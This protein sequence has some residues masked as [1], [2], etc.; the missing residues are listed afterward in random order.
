MLDYANRPPSSE[1][2]ASA[3]ETLNGSLARIGPEGVVSEPQESDRSII[4]LIKSGI[5]PHY[6]HKYSTSAHNFITTQ[7]LDHTLFDE[8]IV[9][10]ADSFT[11]GRQCVIFGEHE[12]HADYLLGWYTLHGLQVYPRIAM[13]DSVKLP[14][15]LN[16]FG[17][18]FIRHGAFTINRDSLRDKRVA[19]YQARALEEVFREIIDEGAS[20]LIFPRGTRSYGKDPLTDRL[21]AVYKHHS[22]SM[23][24]DALDHHRDVDIRTATFHYSPRRVEDGLWDLLRMCKKRKD[25]LRLGYRGG[26]FTAFLTW[27]L[28]R[29]HVYDKPPI[30]HVRFSTPRP[31]GEIVGDPAQNGLHPWRRLQAHVI[32]E[33]TNSYRIHQERD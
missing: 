33:V 1:Y 17:F 4:D 3:N 18:D 13:G 22:F 2:A 25:I 6:D 10:G 11:G 29:R 12:S 7:G 15:I 9:E 28:G 30:A 21:D 19:M 32:K 20:I 5:R 26:D 8:I 23:I 31:Y 27:M 24:T 14:S 16:P